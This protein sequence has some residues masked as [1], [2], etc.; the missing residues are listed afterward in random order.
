MI[1][2]NPLTLVTPVK[3]GEHDNLD[4]LLMKI[5]AR[6]YKWFAPAI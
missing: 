2:Q 5:R 3:N 4:A 6:S 1:H